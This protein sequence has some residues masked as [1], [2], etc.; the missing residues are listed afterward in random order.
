MSVGMHMIRRPSSVIY[1]I[2]EILQT[3]SDK[4]DANSHHLLF[5]K[6]GIEHK[7][8]IACTLLSMYGSY[9]C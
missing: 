6:E 8:N 9:T 4:V 5:A 1:L 7:A 2:I 3:K